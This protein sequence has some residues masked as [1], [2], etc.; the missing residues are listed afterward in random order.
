MSPKACFLYFAF[1]FTN[2]IA[3]NLIEDRSCRQTSTT[4]HCEI[5]Q[6]GIYIARTVNRNISR[7]YFGTFTDSILV[8]NNYPNID[9][10]E[11]QLSVFNKTMLAHQTGKM[12]RFEGCGY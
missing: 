10:V 9:Y 3:I 12:K 1:C 5:N 8:L 11:Y 6:P 2:S 7:I 4:I